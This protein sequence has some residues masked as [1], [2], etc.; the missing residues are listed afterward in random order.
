MPTEEFPTKISSI[1]TTTEGVNTVQSTPVNPLSTAVTPQP[2]SIESSFSHSSAG[3][4]PLSPS[5]KQPPSRKTSRT[6][7]S[8]SLGQVMSDIGWQARREA[9]VDKKQ[10]AEEKWVEAEKRVEG[11]HKKEAEEKKKKGSQEEGGGKRYQEE[12]RRK[13]REEDK[14][15][16]KNKRLKKRKKSKKGIKGERRT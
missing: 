6:R 14:E 11:E 1:D 8:S 5:I 4:P 16:K 12:E 3:S 15:R 10:E 7:F 13:R 2:I 9:R